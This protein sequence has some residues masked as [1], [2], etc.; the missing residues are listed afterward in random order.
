MGT[1]HGCHLLL[2]LVLNVPHGPWVLHCVP[3]PLALCLASAVASSAWLSSCQRGGPS[4]P[5]AALGRTCTHTHTHAHTH[6]RT[7]VHRAVLCIVFACTCP[8]SRRTASLCPRPH[9]WGQ[10]GL[11][12]ALSCGPD[13]AAALCGA[14]AAAVPL[15][16]ARGVQHGSAP[17]SLPRTRATGGHPGP[18]G[19]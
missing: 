11:S 1:P 2:L 18:P 7:R 8:G 5:E 6:T 12:R 3:L 15:S 13:V 19:A 14:E 9:L 4:P 17:C 10:V 16:P